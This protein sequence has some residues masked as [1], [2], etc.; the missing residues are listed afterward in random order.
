MS[1]EVELDPLATDVGDDDEVLQRRCVWLQVP[2][3][4]AV[5]ARVA[6]VP[7]EPLV[8]YVHGSGPANSGVTWTR[9]ISRTARRLPLITKAV[10]VL[11]VMIQYKFLA[12]G[13]TSLYSLPPRWGRVLYL[14]PKT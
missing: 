5:F 3:F 8:L 6:G 9:C 10:V 13:I 4:G 7:T 1:E 14:Q 2:G 11:V 12:E